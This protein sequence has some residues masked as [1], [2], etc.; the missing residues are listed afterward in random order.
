[1]YGAL[2]DVYSS[3]VK[4]DVMLA[5]ALRFVKDVGEGRNLEKMAVK[6]LESEMQTVMGEC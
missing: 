3:T 6:K 2:E 4:V 1:M 5:R